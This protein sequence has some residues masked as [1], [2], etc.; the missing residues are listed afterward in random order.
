MATTSPSS[1]PLPSRACVDTVTASRSNITLAMITPD[2]RPGDLRGDVGGEL[3]RREPAEDAVGER[4]DRVEVSAGDR[5]EREDERDESRRGG[6][7]VLE[8]LQS[9]VVG[10]EALR[11]DPR[12]DDDGGEER[13]A[14]AF[15]RGF[16][17]E[18]HGHRL[19]NTAGGARCRSA[20]ARRRVPTSA[21][22]RPP[23][24]CAVGN[25][26]STGSA[27]TRPAPR[28]GAPSSGGSRAAGTMPS[29]STR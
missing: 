23:S 12:P 11:E 6:G 20:L 10:R 15:G 14:D 21:R 4:H 27:P 29:S 24:R 8:Q 25:T 5:A 9:D 13:G 7:G 28:R 22:G 3:P 16:A 2:A 1:T 19:S 26:S 17:C 18:R